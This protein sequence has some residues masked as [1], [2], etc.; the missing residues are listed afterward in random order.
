MALESPG[1]VC[2]V[3]LK[4]VAFAPCHWSDISDSLAGR[5]SLGK[6]KLFLLVNPTYSY[7][8][9]NLRSVII[10]NM[11]TGQREQGKSLSFE[12]QFSRREHKKISG[13]EIELVDITPPQIS[14]PTPILLAPG[15][16][17][18][19]S[20]YEKSLKIIY[21]EKRRALTIGYSQR[22]EETHPDVEV[23]KASLLL[24]V[25]EDKGI[26]K[27]DVIAHSE[28]AIYTLIAATIEPDRFRNVVLDKPAGLIGHDSKTA[29]MGRFVKLMIQEAVL[30]PKGV[31]DPTGAVRAGLRTALYCAENPK[32]VMEELDALTSYDISDLIGVLKDKGVMVSVISGVDDPLFPVNRQIDNMRESGAPP[33]EG[34]YSVIGGHNELSIN[35]GKHTALAVNALDSLQ[36]K[37][38]IAV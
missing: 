15:W 37:R 26:K 11:E 34:Y 10:L 6:P 2:A 35:A 33:I 12:A 8:P 28:G 9:N 36:R 20:T 17:E 4:S 21:G 7:F 38:E 13:R 14:D 27:A 1:T 3:G 25:L 18:N 29:L 31:T 24:Q 16:S 32:R 22:G 5:F 19:P 30:R 23:R